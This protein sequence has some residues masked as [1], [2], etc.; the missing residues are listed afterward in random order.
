M[1][2]RIESNEFV[3]IDTI[4]TEGIWTYNPEV[5]KTN[6]NHYLIYFSNSKVNG[7]LDIYE[8][9]IVLKKYK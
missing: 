3:T 4:S 8:N 2:A 9:E 1:L 6:D 5:I 7:V